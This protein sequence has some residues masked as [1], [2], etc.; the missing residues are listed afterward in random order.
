MI[1]HATL[2]DIPELVEL[3]RAM[4]AEA[5]ALNHA[6]YVAEKVAQAMELAMQT[7]LVLVHVNEAGAIDGGF[8]GVVR[9]RWYSTNL[10]LVDLAFYVQGDRRGGLAAFRLLDAVLTWAQERG[11]DPRDVLLGST[12]GIQP[13][14]T[15]NF[16]RRMG[17]HEVGGLY[18]LGSY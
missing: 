15:G 14:R 8:A 2:V 13:Q 5:V 17:F 18:Q 10:M 9:E 4:H 3:G 6:P 7:G 1:R 12:T 16:L 11:I